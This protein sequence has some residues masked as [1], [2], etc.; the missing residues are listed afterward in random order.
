MKTLAVIA[1]LLTCALPVAAQEWVGHVGIGGGIPVNG[2]ND[3]VKG[4]VSVTAGLSRM[5]GQ[6]FMLGAFYKYN[7]Y[8]LDEGT[9]S[10]RLEMSSGSLQGRF[11]FVPPTSG[12]LAPYIGVSLEGIDALA[13][14]T[15]PESV[16]KYTDKVTLVGVAPSVGVMIPVAGV[17]YI[18][19]SAAYQWRTTTGGDEVGTVDVSVGFGFR[20]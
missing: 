13:T 10:A 3:D 8:S 14:T 17:G 20:F 12:D 5:I 15:S 11:L 19:P 16:V 1:I 6:H 7:R 18:E 2:F 9:E 4:G